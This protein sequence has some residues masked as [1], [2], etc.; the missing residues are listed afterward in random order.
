MP[1]KLVFLLLPLKYVTRFIYLKYLK[2]NLNKYLMYKFYANICS[3]L[4]P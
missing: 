2:C 4:I 1:D 3:Y